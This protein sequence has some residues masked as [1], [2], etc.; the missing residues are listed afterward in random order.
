[1]AT[2]SL[3]HLMSLQLVIP[4]RVALQQSPPP[5]HQPAAT[6]QQWAALCNQHS[7][8]CNHLNC[9]LTLGVHPNPHYVV[10]YRYSRG[11]PFGFSTL[12]EPVYRLWFDLQAFRAAR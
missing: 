9:G 8:L 6:L 12:L 3:I 7:P 11:E 1:M 10:G 5:L 4:W 2:P